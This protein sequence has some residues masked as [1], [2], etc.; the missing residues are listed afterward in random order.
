[1]EEEG[2]LPAGKFPPLL[3]DPRFG[4]ADLFPPGGLSLSGFVEL[5][6]L[7]ADAFLFLGGDAFVFLGGV[8]VGEVGGLFRVEMPLSGGGLGQLLGVLLGVLC[9]YPR[10]GAGLLLSGVAA[11]GVVGLVGG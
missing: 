2:V 7:G 5:F 6:P 1:M 3:A 4:V 8:D 10:L 9:G 11:G